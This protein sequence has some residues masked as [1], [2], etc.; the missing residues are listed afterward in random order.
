MYDTHRSDEIHPNGRDAIASQT[1]SQAAGPPAGP[2]FAFFSGKGGVGKTTLA[3]ATA[4]HLA[5]AGHRVL[6]T[7]TDPAHSLSDVFDR[8]IGDQGVVIEPNLFAL[9]VDSTARWAQAAGQMEDQAT[10]R[11]GRKG[12]LARTLG[13]TVRMLGEAPGVDEFMSLELLIE[14][15]NSTEFDRVVFDTAPTGHTLRLLTLPGMLDGWVGKLLSI[16][17]TFRKI[18]RAF[19][20]LMPKDARG[21]QA[22]VGQEL[23]DARERI[24]RARDLIGDPA[25]TLFA[26]VT[27]PEAMSVLET[28]RTLRQ[29]GEHDIPVGVVFANQVQPPSDDCAHCRLRH[30]IHRRELDRLGEVVGDVRLASV[31]AKAHVIRGPQA[32]AVLGSEIWNQKPV[33]E[34]V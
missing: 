31:D 33:F 15:M 11:K 34:E 24:A 29:L 19:K 13:E 28:E 30:E 5:R 23:A 17:G 27:I 7:S 25:R 3:A 20:K 10:G 16:R 32:L 6:I 21:E 18:G 22:D 9:E 14:A 1:D 2:R 12:R 4:V 8:S 26:L